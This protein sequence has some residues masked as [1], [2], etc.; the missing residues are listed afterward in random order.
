MALAV[1]AHY[2]RG[3]TSACPGPARV[4]K[5]L[6]PPPTFPRAAPS[7]PT[8]APCM[9]NAAHIN[10]ATAPIASPGPI[11]YAV[12]LKTPQSQ[13]RARKMRA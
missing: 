5:P 8:H 9:C 13:A 6:S 1:E 3:Q 4:R 12:G 2:G 7:S 11:F 10:A